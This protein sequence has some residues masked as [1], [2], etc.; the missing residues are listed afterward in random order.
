MKKF[1]GNYVQVGIKRQTRATRMFF[2]RKNRTP[3]ENSTRARLVQGGEGG[4][5]PVR[6]AHV[7]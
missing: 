7:I 3:K 1:K 5:V 2:L 4:L 6:H